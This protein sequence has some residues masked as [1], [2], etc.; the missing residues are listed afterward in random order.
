MARQTGSRSKPIAGRTTG[1]LIDEWQPSNLS[2]LIREVMKRHG[3][4]DA[5]A[6]LVKLKAIEMFP[7]W[8]DRIEGES[9]W[10]AYVTQARDRVAEELGV[11]RRARSGALTMDEFEQ[12][13]EFAEEWCDGD[14][15]LAQ[16]IVEWLADRN[17]LRL[18]K[19]LDA[20]GELI[21]KVGSVEAAQSAIDTMKKMV[22]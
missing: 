15:E 7:S 11:S 18:R 6:R 13:R 14:M 10:S 9:N 12:A 17:V 20:W 22:K 2:E 19:A 16:Q 8:R 5:K 3:D 4:P 21:E 1:E